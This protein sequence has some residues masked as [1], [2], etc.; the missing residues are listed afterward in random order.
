MFLSV[1]IGN[2]KTAIGVHEDSGRV[3]HH[4]SVTSDLRRTED[5]YT[6]LL[7][8]L[9]RE[10]GAP[11]GPWRGAMICSVV[12]G[13]TARFAGAL[14]RVFGVEALILG[15]GSRLNVRNGYSNPSEVGMDRLA[16]AAGGRDL[17]GAPLI[18]VDFGTATTLDV[19]TGRGVYIGGCI[20]PGVEASAEALFRRTAKLPQISIESAPEVLGR[21]TVESIRSGLFYGAVGAVDGLIERL[22]EVTKERGRVVAT[23]GLGQTLA[24]HSRH[25]ERADP[26]L[27]LHGLWILWRLNTLRRRGGGA[28]GAKEPRRK[29]R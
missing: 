21:T 16:N 4:W 14:A 12:P 19:I 27:T 11:A 29:P 2:T 26:Y 23:D 22:W 1:D 28:A 6:A 20:L 3:A 18:V 13:L 8:Q 7:R 10:D 5:E 25:I 9:S 17:Y 15:P 24:A